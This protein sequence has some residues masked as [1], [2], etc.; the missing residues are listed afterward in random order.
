MTGK[1]VS[2]EMQ[3]QFVEGTRCLR[4]PYTPHQLQHSFEALLA[5]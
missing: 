4:K 3:G 2:G 1:F 5:A